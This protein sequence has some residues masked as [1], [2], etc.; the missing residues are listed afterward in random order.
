MFVLNPNGS[1]GESGESG[2]F[3][4]QQLWNFGTLG[5]YFGVLHLAFMYMD[6]SGGSSGE[7]SSSNPAPP[8]IT[9]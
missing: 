4:S 6:G 2:S 7:G 8:P 1:G 3:L 9:K 5:F